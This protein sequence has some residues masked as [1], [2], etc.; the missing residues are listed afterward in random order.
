[1][2]ANCPQCG[3]PLTVKE[4]IH[5]CHFCQGSSAKTQLGPRLVTGRASLTVTKKN[6]DRMVVQEL[7]NFTLPPAA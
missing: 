3:N 6:F 2:R 7:N 1:M 5:N 4:A